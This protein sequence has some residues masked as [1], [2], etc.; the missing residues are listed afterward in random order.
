MSHESAN[1][2]RPWMTPSQALTRSKP[3]QGPLASIIE[4]R[5]EVSRFGFRLGDFGLLIASNTLSEVVAQ[6][7]IYPVPNTPA[8]VRGLS[9]LRGSLVPVFDL[10]LLLDLPLP[11]Q[12]SARIVLVMDRGEEAVGIFIDGLPRVVDISRAIQQTP[13]VPTVLRDHVGRAYIENGIPWLEF[14]HERFFRGLQER[15]NG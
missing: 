13:P 10:H 6:A 3:L 7:A 2:A 5:Q 8:W 15:L 1:R 4:P 14:L 11:S 12:K 9:N